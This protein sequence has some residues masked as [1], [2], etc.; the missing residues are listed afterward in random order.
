MMYALNDNVSSKLPKEISQVLE[1]RLEEWSS[2]Y[3]GQ[4]VVGP[5]DFSGK[6]LFNSTVYSVPVVPLP[7]SPDNRLCVSS[8][9]PTVLHGI[10]TQNHLEII[11]ALAELLQPLLVSPQ[12]PIRTVSISPQLEGSGDANPPVI[13][14]LIPTIYEGDAKTIDLTVVMLPGGDQ[15][16]SV[17]SRIFGKTSASGK[18]MAA[19]TTI[20]QWGGGE[21]V[22]AVVSLLVVGASLF[23]LTRH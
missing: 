8:M 20:F 12:S 4:L 11:A 7:I 21:T 19:P 3:G 2:R 18:N 22:V 23:R 15:Q 14:Q 10:Y 6:M 13:V 9:L 16:A 1:R 17:L 5:G